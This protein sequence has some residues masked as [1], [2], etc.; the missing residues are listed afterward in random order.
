MSKCGNC[1]GNCASCGGCA[2]SLSITEGELAFLRLLGQIPFLPVVRKR[3]DMVPVYPEEPDRLEENSLVLQCLEKK[4]LISIDY[5]SPLGKNEG[6]TYRTYP[7]HGSMGL[8]QRGYTVLEQAEIQ[9]F[10]EE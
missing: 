6:E 5:A 8:T 4:G 1:G 9:G 3:D 7:V 2:R 10:T